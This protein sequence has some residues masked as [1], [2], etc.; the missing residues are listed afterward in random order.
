[1][2][3]TA[4][5]AELS[6]GPATDSGLTE[7]ELADQCML[8]AELLFGD[9]GRTEPE[10]GWQFLPVIVITSLACVITNDFYFHIPNLR[11]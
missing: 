11:S 8:V 6:L 2:S 4:L 5:W 7:R 1:M 3:A 10:L 9:S